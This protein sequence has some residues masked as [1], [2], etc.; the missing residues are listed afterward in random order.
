M[1]FFRGNDSAANGIKN[2]VGVDLQNDYEIFGLTGNEFD[3]LN[4]V[5]NIAQA[6]GNEAEAM[7]LFYSPST[8]L[9]FLYFTAKLLNAPQQSYQVFMLDMDHPFSALQVTRFNNSQVGI[10]DNLVASDDALMLAFSRGSNASFPDQTE[11][12]YVVDLN[13]YGFTRNLTPPDSPSN[14]ATVDGSLH[15]IPGN[16]T[17][18]DPRTPQLIYAYGPQAG[19]A[20]NPFPARVW[21]FPLIN[22]A[23]G[24]PSTS[25]PLTANGSVF[26]YNGI[27]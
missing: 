24:L 9:D 7:N 5:G 14:A 11:N 27:R 15:F 18:P 6:Q 19:G 1:Y 12:I 2:L 8:N 23:T 10:I 25:Y 26:V 3:G 21:A 22:I 16:T 17:P 13:S 4:F 20:N